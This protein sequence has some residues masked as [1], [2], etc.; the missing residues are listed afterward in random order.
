M[1]S[2]TIKYSIGY[3]ADALGFSAS[4]LCAIHCALV[5]VALTFLPMLGLNFFASHTFEWIMLGSSVLI[6]FISFLIGYYK[7]HHSDEPLS[8]ML[9]AF[10]FFTLGHPREIPNLLDEIFLPLGGI[11]MAYAHYRNWKLCKETNC[12]ICEKK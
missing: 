7:H 6:A 9:I 2:N 10:I 5:L 8:L 12:K 11:M 4:T 3:V 1:K